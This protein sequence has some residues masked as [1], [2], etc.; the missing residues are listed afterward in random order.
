MALFIEIKS[1]DG[2][3]S[4][5]KL[6]P[7]K[8]RFTV[9]LGD[10][11]RIVDDQTGVTPEGIAVKR[12]DNNLIVDGIDAQA[13][14][15]EFAEFY[16][17]CSAG[18]PCE[19][20]VDKG[21]GSAPVAITPGTQPI[22]ALADGAF[23]LYDP[24]FAETAPAAP[25]LSDGTA[26]RYGLYGLGGLAVVGLAAGGG[27]GGGGGDGTRPDGAL[28]LTSSEFVNSRTPNITGEGEPGA[29]VIMRID[30]DG[31]GAP[32]V[33][34]ATTVG[35][36]SRWSI[37]L[38]TAVP[39][40]G[41]LPAGGLPDASNVGITSTTGAGN[42]SLP[43]FTL[44]FDGPPPAP[45]VISAVTPD[46]VVNAAEKQGGFV[47]SGTAEPGTVVILTLDGQPFAS[48]NVDASGQWQTTPPLAGVSVPADGNYALSAVVQD[49]AGNLS[50]V[51]QGSLRINTAPPL[52]E[53]SVAG[54]D[55]R[56][57]IADAATVNF[58]GRTDPNA[59]IE[60][61]WSGVGNQATTANGNGSW[62]IDFAGAPNSPGE[63][64]P[65]SITAT[66]AIGNAVVVGG[67]I[68][69]D[70]QAPTAPIINVVEGDDAVTLA[71][72]AD[73][74]PV[75]GVAEPGADVTVVWG[76]ATRTADVAGNGQWDV[77]FGP[78]DLP[79]GP[80]PGGPSTLTAT[81]A[82]AVGNSAAS[83]RTVTIQQPFAAPTISLVEGD[84][85][86]N[87]AERADGV[88]L[89]GTVQAG[90]PGV[91]VTW[92][93]FSAAAT[94]SGTSWN[95]AVPI[96]QVPA[97]GQTT[98][99]ATIAGTG[100]GA[101]ATRGVTIDTAPPPTPVVALVTGDDIINLTDRGPA[102]FSVQGLAGSTEAG[103]IV[104]VELGT[105][106]R[107]VTAGASGAWTT[108]PFFNADISPLTT[109]IQLAVTATDAANNSSAPATRSIVV[110][111][112]IPLGVEGAVP[113][114]MSDSKPSILVDQGV[115]AIQNQD[116]FLAIDSSRP[117]PGANPTGTSDYASSSA[118]LQSLLT[119]DAQSS[120]RF[121]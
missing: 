49:R 84:N 47:I 51:T 35:P 48:A 39:D 85:I 5:T 92:G 43:T 101:S 103:A 71:E 40:S 94:I 17:V 24:N 106:V 10:N 12:I 62:S 31:D 109:P 97:D 86:V 98:V 63:N 111:G 21:A 60:I 1:A 100:G 29:R 52:L 102:G 45:A 11:Y 22:G 65:Y 81:V 36:D 19:L 107:V 83:Q 42:A 93:A 119:D 33:T 3:V 117:S 59:I 38:A 9:R 50:A 99:T 41:A 61:Q 75:R 77:L 64:F 120:G 54:G 28:R 82:D 37:N 2:M 73:G 14:S 88:I 16:S 70:L 56:V 118:A 55:N 66:N 20:T 68:L 108:A 18:S 89:S 113:L 46:N 26:L 27:G 121:A 104:I 57:G 44:T 72:R 74:V 78:N 15:V 87:A 115:A 58:S 114:P 32:D 69:V 30:T 79:A 4:R 90:S 110:E 23:V 34:Y 95:L 6:D 13:T 25:S 67:Q 53:A 7:G 105:A 8:N 96:A 76:S 91:S 116:V 80:S 112:A